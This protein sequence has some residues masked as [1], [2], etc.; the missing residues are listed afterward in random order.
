MKSF[1]FHGALCPMTVGACLIGFSVVTQSIALGQ[2]GSGEE[3]SGAF[4]EQAPRKSLLAT[5]SFEEKPIRD[6]AQSSYHW[7]L[8]LVLRHGAGCGESVASSD[9]GGNLEDGG[10]TERR[11]YDSEN[12][13]RT[14]TTGC[15]RSGGSRSIC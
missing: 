13:S 8:P 14:V 12:H 9:Y 6:I 11:R 5:V 7:L 15:Q 4:S 10:S 1:W 3:S 2:S